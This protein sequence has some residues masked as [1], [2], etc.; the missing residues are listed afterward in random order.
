MNIKVKGLHWTYFRLA[1]GTKKK[2]W[3]AWRGGPPLT[4]E[5]GS[6][7]FI[8]RYNAA[9]ASRLITPEGRLLALLQ[10]Y[11]RSTEFDGLRPRNL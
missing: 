3:Y 11:Q 8:A 1:D 2:Y 6:A 4:G 9:V 10:G 7:E 5:F